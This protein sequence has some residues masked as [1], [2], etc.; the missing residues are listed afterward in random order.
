VNSESVELK[1][2]KAKMARS[3][4]VAL[5]RAE[6]KTHRS[7]KKTEVLKNYKEESFTPVT[8]KER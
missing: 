1:E 4:L 6:L 5:L 8:K 7:Q 2:Q 3:K